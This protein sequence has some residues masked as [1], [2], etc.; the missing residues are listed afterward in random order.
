MVDCER[1][2][3][4]GIG[5]AAVGGPL[6]AVISLEDA[7]AVH[8]VAVD[9]LERSETRLCVVSGTRDGIRGGPRAAR[10]G[11]AS[12]RTPSRGSRHWSGSRLASRDLGRQQEEAL[13]RG[14]MLNR[15]AALGM[16]RSKR[17]PVG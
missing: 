1:M 15:M 7:S 3:S 6:K 16:S 10:P 2:T 4:L 13:M 5:V 9:L 12:R 11:R 14:Q 17:V 8:R